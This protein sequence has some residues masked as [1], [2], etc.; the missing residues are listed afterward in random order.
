MKTFNNKVVEIQFFQGLDGDYHVINNSV[1]DDVTHDHEIF[2]NKVEAEICYLQ[3][4][5]NEID[6]NQTI[7]FF[8]SGTDT[9]D[10]SIEVRQT[11]GGVLVTSS[12]LE[13]ENEFFPSKYA[14]EWLDNYGSEFQKLNPDM[15]YSIT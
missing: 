3:L 14:E 13:I 5:A 10:F 7:N 15:K 9:I 11:D 1:I 12:E 2:S 6:E 8:Y 4:V